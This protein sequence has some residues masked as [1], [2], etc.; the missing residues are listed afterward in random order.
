MSKNNVY[1]LAKYDVS[2]IQE[3]IFAT[4]RLRENAG[5]SCQVTR[6]LEQYL[7]DAI[8]EAVSRQAYILSWKTGNELKL[9]EDEGIAAEIIY[10]GG[11]NAM[12]LFRER[13]AFQKVC[14]ILGRQVAVSCQG[15][16]LVAACLE[17]C[18][19]NFKDDI[20]NLNAKLAQ[21][22]ANMVRQ[23]VYSPFPVVEQDHLNYQPITRRCEAENYL[24]EDMT[25]MKYQKLSAYKWSKVHKSEKLY[26]SIE[27]IEDYDY[28]VNMDCLCKN[29]G[30]NSYIAVVHIDGNGMGKQMKELLE[31]YEDYGEAISGL[32][33]KSIEISELFRSVYKAMLSKLQSYSERL[34]NG[35]SEEIIF[36]LRPIVLD[37][38]DFT[39]LCTADLAIPTAAGF[40]EML[41]EIQKEQEEKITACAGIA[42]V[43]SHFPFY[44]AYQI[45]EESCSNA[46]EKWYQDRDNQK[47]GYLDFQVLKGSKL[48]VFEGHTDGRQRPYAVTSQERPDSLRNLY[49]TI[50]EME[51]WPS[52][53]LHK[54]Y[55]AILRGNDDM[56]ILER[57]FASRGYQLKS[58]TC[59]SAWQVSSLYD[60]LEIRDLCDIEL[61][62]DFLHIQKR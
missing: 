56:E 1:I 20:Q 47:I 7:P 43:H 15:I 17:T 25:E 13:A 39:Y 51:K 8:E 53:R 6:I 46:K 9:L 19:Q 33:K 42:F 55:Q 12:V 48:D 2:G 31:S 61:L 3:Y 37:G 50:Y 18:L 26:P 16:Y 58:L 30:E 21:N 11:G 62:A 10:I 36:P 59:G 5:A 4:N 49:E 57:E 45:A 60:A 44:V 27:G 41:S 24:I 23:P 34:S 38:D 32:R 14:Q 54:I 22:K 52:N 35:E 29:H 28:P 40:L